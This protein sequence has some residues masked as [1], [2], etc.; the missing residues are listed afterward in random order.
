MFS[1]LLP[2]IENSNVLDLFSG[3]GALGLETIS[4]GAKS[5]VLCD[6]SR[7]AVKIINENVTNAK[8]N[9]MVEILLLDYKK[10]LAQL[11]GR[12]F[13]IIFLDPPYKTDFDIQAIKIILTEGLLATD[14][15]IVVETDS[16]EKQKAIED[17]NIN[18]FKVRKY[19]RVKLI[20]L[21]RKG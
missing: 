14:G 20:F 8:M 15:V 18:I 13:D 21:N 16:D 7:I 4:R 9:N 3:S 6:N 17:L 12:K 19:G 10:A 5:A 2:W 1:I 11:K